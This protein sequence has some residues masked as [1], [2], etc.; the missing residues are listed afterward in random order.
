MPA[1]PDAVRRAS[2]PNQGSRES[3]PGSPSTSSTGAP[4]KMTRWLSEARMPAPRYQPRSI[5][6]PSLRSTYA[7]S[8]GPGSS[9]RTRI[10]ARSIPAGARA[11]DL[12]A[13]QDET[14]SGHP[15]MPCRRPFP[16]GGVRAPDAEQQLAGRHGAE[17]A[18]AQRL[19]GG[20]AQPLDGVQVPVEDAP[21]RSVRP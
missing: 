4:W 15:P 12:D 5:S 1:Q 21:D 9:P 6:T 2:R 10:S 7:S 13:H 19:G 17:L 20:H 18:G 16:G 8:G 3:S 14:A 11:E